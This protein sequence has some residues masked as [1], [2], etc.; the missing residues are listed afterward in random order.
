MR[1]IT[2]S[3]FKFLIGFVLVLILSALLAPWLHSFLPFKFHRILRRLIMIGTIGLVLWL[4]RKRRQSLGQMGLE[5]SENCPARWGQGF[6]IG[7]IL[8]GLMS[9][10]QWI[11]GARM[12]QLNDADGWHW[13][14]FFIK[15]LTSGLL[16]GLVE[17]FFFRGFLFLTL[18]EL[19]NTKASLIVTN[20]IYAMVH[21]FPRT[22]LPPGVEPNVTE[23]FRLLIASVTPTP[24]KMI[25]AAPS[26]LGLFLFGL[27]LSFTYLRTGSL[28]SSMGVHGGAVFA[29]KLNR[30][31]IPEVSDK[32][33][34]LSGSKNLYD[35]VVGLIVLSLGVLLTKNWADRR[36]KK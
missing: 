35:G 21:F 27:I 16:I 19:W 31:F 18:K 2:K 22:K 32:M 1:E 13:I 4:M 24:E 7:I 34:F 17:E 29:L 5:W 9:V 6:S 3:I 20:L 25:L 28:Y 33:N 15:A 14:G 12:W 8:V 23:S 30:R 10:F 36:I 26:V 11:L